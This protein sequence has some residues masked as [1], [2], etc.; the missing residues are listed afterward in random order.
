M[1]THMRVHLVASI[2]VACA[3]ILAASQNGFAQSPPPA[4]PAGII[5][6]DLDMS[7]RRGGIA[8]ATETELNIP[9][10]YVE[11]PGEFTGNQQILVCEPGPDVVENVTA[12]YAQAG[13]RQVGQAR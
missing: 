6:S 5:W 10:P 3:G 2:I 13:R 4:G 11:V 1:V 12:A 9:R 8:P 7:L